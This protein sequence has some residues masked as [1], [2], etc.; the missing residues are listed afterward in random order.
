MQSTYNTFGEQEGQPP[1]PYTQSHVQSTAPTMNYNQSSTLA[2][3][4]SAPMSP[5]TSKSH[6]KQ[7]FQKVIK[8]KGRINKY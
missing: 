6:T 2:P 8:I 7:Q 1:Q 4:P 5:N 3:P